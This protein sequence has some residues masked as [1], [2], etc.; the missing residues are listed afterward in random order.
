MQSKRFWD[1]HPRGKWL[2]QHHIFF[3]ELH[4]VF[5]ISHFSPQSK[6]SVVVVVVVLVISAVVSAVLVTVE[7]VTVEVEVVNVKLEL[8][9]VLVLVVVN[10]KLVVEQPPFPW[11]QHQRFFSEDQPSAAPVQ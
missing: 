11:S 10:V 9:V 5:Q 7:V 4:A 3:S 2:A 6:A 8:I 1:E